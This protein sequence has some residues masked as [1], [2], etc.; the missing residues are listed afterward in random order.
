MPI[1]IVAITK[2]AI[3]L[4]EVAINVASVGG[5]GYNGWLASSDARRKIIGH[6]TGQYCPNQGRFVC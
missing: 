2:F 4:P 5:A 6:H 1:L 3:A